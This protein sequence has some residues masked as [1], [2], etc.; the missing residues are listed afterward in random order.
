MTI[1]S[2][3]NNEREVIEHLPDYSDFEEESNEGVVESVEDD[4]T[5][6]GLEDFLEEEKK[7]TPEDIARSGK[8]YKIVGRVY[9]VLSIIALPFLFYM[10]LFSISLFAAPDSS[11]T[12]WP[13]L[14]ALGI[15]FIPFSLILA[16]VLVWKSIKRSKYGLVV[17]CM[18]LPFGYTLLFFF[19]W[20]LL[21]TIVG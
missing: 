6:H 20:S 5:K 8:K 11:E 13:Y 7:V 4:R 3:N 1:E 15:L 10:Q 18:L 14:L 9:S 16:N 12:V 21:G 17:G 19:L 2:R